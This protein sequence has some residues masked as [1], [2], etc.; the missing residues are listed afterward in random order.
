MKKDKLTNSKSGGG[1]LLN[2]FIL[3]LKHF[4]KANKKP[5]FICL[6]IDVLYYLL[7]NNLIRHA[8][9]IE[10]I[11]D[12]IIFYLF[13]LLSFFIL[14]MIMIFI[15]YVFIKERKKYSKF[16]KHFSCYF[17][18]MLIILILVWPGIYKGDEYD[19]LL[20]IRNFDIY[21][22]QHYLTCIFYIISLCIIPTIG[23]ITIMQ[24]FIISLIIGYVFSHIEEC[25]KHKKLIAIMYI[26]FLFPP[27]I[28]NNMFTLRSSLISYLILLFVFELIVCI[29]DKKFIHL[30]I[31]ALISVIVGVW[32]SELCYMPLALLIY[33][34]IFYHKELK[35]KKVLIFA[36]F[37]AIL[38]KCISL[39]QK[40]DMFYSST[41]ILNP[42][43][44]LATYDD[45]K[46]TISEEDVHNIELFAPFDKLAHHANPYGISIYFSPDINREITEDQYKKFVFSSI[47]LFINNPIRFLKARLSTF[48]YTNF[49]DDYNITHTGAE[50][51]SSQWTL[52]HNGIDFHEMYSYTKG[53]LNNNQKKALISLIL[54]R[55]S[56]YKPLLMN[57][58]F[59]NLCPILFIT[60]IYLIYLVFSKDFKLIF[61]FLTVLAHCFLVFLTAPTAFWMYYISPYIVL[62]G[63]IYFNILLKI[64]SKI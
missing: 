49:A 26:V 51:P 6:I 10:K 7:I 57:H 8:F 61:I 5:L 11:Y 62:H 59:Y 55:D 2:K 38:Y 46:E 3:P 15:W 12:K 14:Y 42:L 21:Y 17:I 40:Y 50:Q 48:N 29:K 1:Y 31:A 54:L 43:S 34:I 32:R 39:P 58:L 30:F 53:I 4:I 41:T 64:D 56:Q 45:I 63:L 19:I 24:I 52:I 16:I 9:F 25:L 13:V 35:L 22:Y 44:V 36:L 23:G 33:I 47:K 60:I 37:F 28:D 27:I 20:V 18:L